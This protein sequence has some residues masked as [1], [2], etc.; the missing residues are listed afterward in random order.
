M[1]EVT[2]VIPNYNRRELLEAA[3][4]TIRRQTRPFAEICVV[5][6]GSSDGSVETA[7]K[8][9]A[10][11]LASERNEGFSRA[12][13]RG[14]REAR[15]ACIAV[16]NNDV[17]IDG[18]WLELLLAEMESTGAWFATGKILRR[19]H[20][21]ILD[22]AY[23]EISRAGCAWRCGEGRKDGPEWNAP[24]DIA[25]APLTA[26]VFR[27][28]LFQ[29]VGGLDEEFESYLEDV[30]LGLRCAAA[31]LRG[32]YVPSALARHAGSA[33]LGCWSPAKVRLIARNQ[34]LLV[35]K[36]FPRRWWR[37]H[38]WPVVAGQLLWGLVAVRHGAGAAYLKGK[39][40][41]LRRFR[42]ARERSDPPPILA[43]LLAESEARIRRVQEATG[44]DW[45]WR[46]YFAIT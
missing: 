35:A 46:L 30:D 25:F 19:D 4:E 16:L 38:G 40:D 27:R 21:D 2:A 8:L 34:V 3:L 41:G 13:N 15:G 23:D 17:E 37:G 28:E 12:V 42:R 7:R 44:F 31:G 45:Y 32:R 14:I 5:D 39:F 22:G 20:P 29:R 11:V 26:A 10:R 24:R 9:G 43:S 33:T 18:R 1:V 6:N 36:H